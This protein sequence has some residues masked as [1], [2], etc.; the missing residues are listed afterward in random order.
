MDGNVDAERPKV[1]ARTEAYGLDFV[2]PAGDTAV[3]ASLARHGEFA[4]PELDFLVAQAAREG[5]GSFLDL[6]ANIGSI[7]LPFAKAQPTWRVVAVEAHREIAALLAANAIN[8]GCDNVEA[9]HAAVGESRRVADFPCMPLAGGGN[10]GMSGF[11]STSLTTEPVMMLTLDELAPAD[12]RLIKLDVEGYEAPV[13]SAAT[14]TLNETRPI[15]LIEAVQSE[16]RR[17]VMSLLQEAGYAVYWFYAPWVT[18]R[19]LKPSAAADPTKGD[20]NIIAVPAGGA[21]VWALPPAQLADQGWPT[22]AAAY[23]YLRDYGYE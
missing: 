6:G 13:L 1:I 22:A 23:P 10:L 15:W 7:C 11:G 9:L 8:N 4:R 12:T 3:G 18:H 16:V 5:S 14:R 17:N 21:A 19:P 20:A 2:Y